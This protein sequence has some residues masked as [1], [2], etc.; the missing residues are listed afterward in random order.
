MGTNHDLHIIFFITFSPKYEYFGPDSAQP[1][2][3][4]TN[5]KGELVGVWKEDFGH[6]FGF[7]LLEKYPR[8]SF[9][10]WRPDIRADKIYEH[11]FENGLI[12]RS[13]PSKTVKLTPGLIQ[14]SYIYS[15]LME[16]YLNKIKN[17]NSNVVLMLP[18]KFTGISELISRK[19]YKFF[20]ILNF[21]FVNNEF[22]LNKNS[23]NIF[24]H[25]VSILSTIKREKRI[26]RVS[27]L[28]V[29][30]WKGIEQL[31]KQYKCEVRFNQLG[32]DTEYWK[33]DT[34]QEEAKREL[35]IQAKNILLFSSRLTA[36]YQIDKVLEV[37]SNFRGQDFLCVFTSN[38]PMDYVRKLNQMVKDLYIDKHVLF[39]GYLETD[40]LKKYYTACDVFC[41]T[42]KKNAG[43]GSATIALLME[44]PVLATNSGLVAELLEKHESGLLLSPEYN[45]DWKDAFTQLI[46]CNPIDIK[47]LD[48]QIVEELVNWDNRLEGWMNSFCN[49]INA[50]NN[51]Y[52]FKE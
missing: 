39:T 16:S 23:S 20:P 24:R 18:S 44:K 28:S 43:P 7:K 15:P 3:Q 4:W 12:H 37:I 10:V 36:E 49:T 19:Y 30:H 45:G 48:R 51:K 25:A 42:C 2:H 29:S 35:N 5:N 50:F 11:T 8:I 38:G 13:F 22:L 27:L 52:P 32:M 21:H 17:S 14:R 6:M 41:T 47:I 33:P 31:K 9:E 1:I 46:E 40:L 34:T 26:K